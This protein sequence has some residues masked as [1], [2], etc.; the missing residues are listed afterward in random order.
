MAYAA[1]PKGLPEITLATRVFK[2]G[3]STI[4][5][6]SSRTAILVIICG[7]NL[8]FRFSLA[9]SRGN[10]QVKRRKEFKFAGDGIWVLI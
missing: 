9:I 3:I 4:G 5:E 1:K 10:A 6:L 8:I 7:K 2:V